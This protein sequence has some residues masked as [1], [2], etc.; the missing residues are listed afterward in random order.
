MGITRD[1]EKRIQLARRA[2]AVMGYPSS[3]GALAFAVRS[4]AIKDTPFLPEDVTLA[5]KILRP[6]HARI[7]EKSTR[8]KLVRNLHD[9]DGVI[10]TPYRC[11]LVGR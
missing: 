6:D 2:E 3:S 10:E 4:G 7:K 1:Q 11:D 9:L 8:A 5:D